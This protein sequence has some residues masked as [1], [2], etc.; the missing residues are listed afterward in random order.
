MLFKHHHTDFTVCFCVFNL[1]YTL[2]M[3][4]S[5][6]KWFREDLTT[7]IHFPNFH[8]CGP[9]ILS[10]QRK[11][12]IL[13]LLLFMLQPWG[14]GLS[15][16]RHYVKHHTNRLLGRPCCEEVPISICRKEHIIWFFTV[17]IEWFS[18]FSPSVLSFILSQSMPQCWCIFAPT[19][20][21]LQ[22]NSLS[23]VKFSLNEK[24]LCKNQYCSW[25]QPL[26]GFVLSILAVLN[27]KITQIMFTFEKSHS[28]HFKFHT[29]CQKA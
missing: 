11:R 28:F 23:K 24:N 26:V 9:I 12:R 4:L 14:F 3:L 1:A 7:A 29:L 2:G 27:K 16:G 21:G 5:I 18:Y 13:L 8:I 20:Y 15:Q 25:L 6:L 17:G 22:V 10:K 19:E